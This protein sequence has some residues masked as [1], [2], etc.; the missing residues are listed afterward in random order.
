[1]IL[2]FVHKQVIKSFVNTSHFFDKIN[3]L[4]KMH[5]ITNKYFLFDMLCVRRKVPELRRPPKG[6]YLPPDI[7]NPPWYLRIVVTRGGCNSGDA[8]MIEKKSM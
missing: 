6:P 5:V 4:T 3:R 1:M 2:H 8:C 7:F